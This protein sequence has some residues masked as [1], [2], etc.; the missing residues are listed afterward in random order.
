MTATI[1]LAKPYTPNKLR[2]PVMVSEKLDGVPA[3]IHISINEG[4]YPPSSLVS[5][6][7]IWTVQTRQGKPFVAIHLQ[8]EALAE[9]L[10]DM[11]CIGTFV[12]VAEVTHQDHTMPFKDVSGYCRRQEQC[13]ALRLN[14]FDFY[15]PTLVA[16]EPAPDLLPFGKR[17]V[18]AS[19]LVR[20]MFWCKMVH[21]ILC[22]DAVDLAKA[23]IAVKVMHKDGFIP[24]GAV[25]RSCHDKWEEGKR[26]WGYQ[27]VVE[28]P[29]TEVF[30]TGFEEAVS[31]EGE[32]LG[33]VG[34]M[35]GHWMGHN[36][37][38]GPGKLTHFG[39]KQL[40]DLRNND[41]WW[42][43]PRWATVSYKRDPSY[44]SLREPTFQHWRPDHEP[45]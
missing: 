10:Q 14:V 27:K 2:F 34:R 31:K 6:R 36:I 17:I 20:G 4:I 44:N 37:G 32:P 25:I 13:D 9:H 18:L 26:G 41:L 15:R 7:I 35:N 11:G 39:R 42:D 38:V 8:V 21:Q 16:N 19:G 45:E 22:K 23:L 3:K 29:T 1:M 40:W 33:M 43:T 28:R 30:I 24:E 12:F 5:K